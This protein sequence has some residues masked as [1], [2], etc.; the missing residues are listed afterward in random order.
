M[1]SVIIPAYKAT[2]YIDE[3]ILS[4][5]GDCEILI[6]I[7]DCQDTYNHL[8]NHTYDNVQVF[9]FRR[10]VGP[11]TIKNTL[12]DCA[13]N[14]VILFFD[15]DDVMSEG[16]INLVET[17]IKNV[18]YLPLNYINFT[19]KIVK[20]G[21]T[22]NDAVIAIKKDVFNSLNG[23]YPWKC[24]ADTEFAYRLSYN[25]LKK[26]NL[27]CVCYYRRLHGENLTMRQETGHGS[28]IRKEYTNIINR[29][30]R[31][32]TWPSPK[33]KTIEDYVKD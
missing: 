11:F 19:K 33:T 1:I 25:Y 10:N 12:V 30:I 17:N 13:K 31:A 18:D 3:C 29:N 8:K 9:Y 22:M 7:D 6:G 14:D 26:G 2:R 15:S 4:I 16:T 23:F 32:N 20:S 28:L 27:Q 21:H 24:G 5:K